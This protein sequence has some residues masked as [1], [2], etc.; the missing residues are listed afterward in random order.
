MCLCLDSSK[1]LGCSTSVTERLNTPNPIG[2]KFKVGCDWLPSGHPHRRVGLG[3]DTG[4]IWAKTRPTL[5]HLAMRAKATLPAS[6]SC[7]EV[8]VQ[9]LAGRFGCHPVVKRTHVL[10]EPIRLEEMRI[11]YYI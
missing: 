10:M 4:A 3:G 2:C 5:S 7:L 11:P 6:Q 9:N 8:M 1:K